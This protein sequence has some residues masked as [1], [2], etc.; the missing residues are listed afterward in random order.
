MIDWLIDKI[1]EKL[2]HMRKKDAWL[3]S[4]FCL[5]IYSCDRNQFGEI[6]ASSEI[7]MSQYIPST[8]S[9]AADVS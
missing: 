3:E 4:M 9:G 1:A 6:A 7:L 5:V 2:L 8:Q